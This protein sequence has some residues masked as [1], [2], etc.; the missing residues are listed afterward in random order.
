MGETNVSCLL[1]VDCADCNGDGKVEVQL[2]ADNFREDD[3]ETC[4]GTGLLKGEDEND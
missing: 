3:C 2:A 1:L 4:Q